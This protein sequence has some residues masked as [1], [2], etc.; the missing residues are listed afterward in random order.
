M[1]ARFLSGS[2]IAA[3][4][5]LCTVTMAARA[6]EI[7]Y[8]LGRWNPD[9]FG[10]QRVVLNVP[11]Q[12]KVTTRPGGAPFMARVRIPWRRRDTHP[13]LKQI[14]V[15]DSA[16][17]RVT[18]VVALS[19]RRDSG[20]V[21]FE[22]SAGYGD[23][24]LYYLPYI[25]SVK[26]NYPKISYPTQ[27]S[28]ADPAWIKSAR[29]SY[30]SASPAV[31]TAFESVDSMSLI[32]PMEVSATDGEVAAL[33]ARFQGQ[34]MVIFPEDRTRPIKMTTDL[35]MRWVAA[36]SSRVLHGT[37]L[38]DEYYAFQLGVWALRPLDSVR[39]RFGALTG[40]AG[41]TV[42]ASAFNCINTDGVDWMGRAYKRTVTVEAGKVSPLWC[43]V[44]IPATAR[45]GAY[46][47]TA[48]VVASG[49]KS[50]V[51]P[52]ALTISAT[53]AVNH[54]DDEPWRLSRLRWL[55]SRLAEDGPPMAPYIPVTGTPAALSVLGRQIALDPLGFPKQ[56]TSFFDPGM[57]R[58]LA[59]GRPMLVKP[60]SLVVADS[61]GHSLPFVPGIVHVTSR[62]SSRVAFSSSGRSG[63]LHLDV[64]GELDFDGN[65]EYRVGLVS[66]RAMPVSDV[67]LTMPLRNDVARFF[68]GMSQMGGNAPDEYDW[69]WDVKRNQD[70]VWIGDVN[71]GVQLTLKDDQYIRPLNTN[72]YQLRPLVM[73]RSWSNNGRGGC[74]FE[75]SVHSYD[76]TCYGGPRTLAKGDTL[77]FNFR[78]LV[79]PFHPIDTK[80]HF[81][82]RYY[83]AY[84]PVDTVKAAGANLVNVHHAT[85]INPYI[86]YPFLRPEAMKAYADS[87]H[88]ANMRFKIYY[89]V[90]ELTN[91]APELWALRSL[92]S[93]VLASGP[94]G[95]HSWLQEHM[96]DDYITGWV[97]PQLR[98]VAMVT[99]GIS[100]WHNFYIEGMQWL[101]QHAGVDGIYLD[102]VA[103]DRATML[104]LR[105]VLTT[106]GTRGEKIDLHSANQ[107]NKADGYT[108]SANLYLEHFPFIDRLWF[109]EYF[110]YDNPPDYW[111]VEMSGI[112]FGLL[113]EMLQGGGNPWR[114]MLFGMTARLPWAGD[115]RELW[116]VWDD[117]GISQATMQGWWTPAPPVTTGRS[118]IL[119]TTYS[120]PG[121][122]LIAVASWARD[123]TAVRLRINW[124]ALGL[125][126]TK[127]RIEA[128]EI[129]NFQP[130]R[131]FRV[132]EPIPVP[133]GRGWV[134]M[135]KP[136]TAGRA[137][138]K[139]PQ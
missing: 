39:V 97:V 12:A 128:P 51:V 49:G 35:P 87:L 47:G 34:P 94:G 15:T 80:T 110:N 13:E 7:P 33:R 69:Q 1:S 124:R 82:T 67:R 45:A 131:S 21:V 73:P 26:S 71:A 95:G 112:P 3:A 133:N 125:D 90:R 116:K 2:A 115:P 130:A 24:Y 5:A 62:T 22:P 118:D 96:I 79:T 4:V 117:F 48:T 14:I 52:I 25:G 109:G 100:R 88:A 60:I 68:M 121:S 126:S 103:F 114:G 76:A 23:Y 99:S 63:A 66:D 72:F 6:Q 119:A 135:V 36:A 27:D 93:D 9:S 78:L 46:H 83:H 102:D 44:M 58:I 113:G 19:V 29:S 31:V 57:T 30:A 86:N 77:W 111:L 61:A 127:V 41:S 81:D 54:G 8:R 43:G 40:P 98:D 70:A 11:Q 18:N 123:T 20:D 138:G 28:T 84:K 104:R 64:H 38:R 122:A 101:T 105:R 17:K 91:R 65:L 56:I 107:F 16:G 136:L 134:L 42:A 106:N 74:H 132:G 92:G 120:R 55:D 59:K 85:E 137:P 53:R 50:S 37:A 10:N 89:T 75:S 139:L 129:A 108:S 32:W